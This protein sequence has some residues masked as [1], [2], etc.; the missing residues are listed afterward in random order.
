LGDE[1]HITMMQNASAPAIY[2]I[3]PLAD[4]RVMDMTKK[5][6]MV[7]GPMHDHVDCSWQ[8]RHD[9]TRTARHDMTRTG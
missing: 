7:M 5:C 4:F 2:I 9:M 8:L 6:R 1:C 3:S